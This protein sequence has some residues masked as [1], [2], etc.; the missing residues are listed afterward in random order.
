MGK[1]GDSVDDLKVFKNLLYYNMTRGEDSTGVGLVPRNSQND[2]R[3]L[4]CLGPAVDLCNNIKFESAIKSG[5]HCAWLGHNRAATVGTISQKNI[6][7]FLF[8]NILGMHNGTIEQ[9]CRYKM[10]DH[11]QFG[12]DSE[13]LIYNIDLVG[14]EKIIPQLE[15]SWTLAWYSRKDHTINFLRNEKR[16]LAYVF[17]EGRKIMYFNS[18]LDTLAG[19]LRRNMVKWDA[20][21]FSI[22]PENMWYSWKIP[23]DGDAFGDPTRTLVEGYKFKA[24]ETRQ[25]RVNYGK[26]AVEE[27]SSSVPLT[28]S[29]TKPGFTLGRPNP[30]VTSP[31]TSAS[32]D[33]GQPLTRLGRKAANDQRD[34]SKEPGFIGDPVDVSGLRCWFRLKQTGIWRDTKMN[35]WML[36][37]WQEKDQKWN[38]RISR[39][40]PRFLKFTVLDVN[41]NHAF[42]HVGKKKKKVIYFRGWK[43]I[44]LTRPEFEQIAK[45]GCSACGRTDIEWGNYVMFVGATQF[46]CEFCALDVP[47]VRSWIGHGIPEA[48]NH[49]SQSVN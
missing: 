2:I 45:C 1:I 8:D 24:P 48:I 30:L 29:V 14:V 28:S 9:H 5:W 22:L 44:E 40:A 16:P 7:P 37:T 4:K 6:H 3:L 18:E 23:K 47:L 10:K 49:P 34:I 42:K 17:G 11:T 41:A 15:G 38:F 32:N 21:K 46:L 31:T 35:Q 20:D 19:A 27:T 12:T 33:S 36:G 39:Q 25:G 13:A 26:Y 43:G